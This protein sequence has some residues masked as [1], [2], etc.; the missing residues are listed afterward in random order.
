MISAVSR[1]EILLA[2]NNSRD[3]PEGQKWSFDAAVTTCFDD[4]LARS[5]P[6]CEAMRRACFDVGVKYV[7]PT[8]DV[9]DL[10]CSR[11]GALAEFVGKFGDNNSY[12][13]VE[14]SPPM[15]SAARGRFVE[16]IEAGVVKIE[17]L[18]LRTTYPAATASLTLAVLTL[19]FVPI[20]YRQNILAQAFQ[21]TRPGGALLLVE[22]VLGGTAAMNR[23]LV[24]VYY[25]GKR[26][27]GY[28]QEEI[29]R[30]RL[31]LEGVLVPV[32]AKWNEDMLRAAGFAEVECFWRSLNFAAWVAV[33]AE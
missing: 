20:E 12:I 16:Q 29:D 18:D 22:K 21:H 28:S 11:G 26:G 10:G 31:S 6:D 9:V 1:I 15:L 17:D 25:D 3:A 27:H 14:I 4:M 8:T 23:L 13:G 19:Q 33:R 24:D 32:T 30:K 2:A 5:I 7:R